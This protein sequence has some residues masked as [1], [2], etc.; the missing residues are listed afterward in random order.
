MTAPW[1]TQPA[2]LPPLYAY[3]TP[4]KHIKRAKREHDTRN[5]YP[6]PILTS[7]A[8][9]AREAQSSPA[10]AALPTLQVTR[11]PQTVGRS[12]KLADFCPSQTN[13]LLSRVH[14]RVR[15]E[16][17]RTRELVLECVGW[18]GCTLT[19]TD[20]IARPVARGDS[21]AAVMDERG[22]LLEMLGTR[23]LLTCDEQGSTGELSSPLTEAPYAM[24]GASPP[25]ASTAASTGLSMEETLAE[26]VL[27]LEYSSTATTNL[28]ALRPLFPVL[29]DPGFVEML[30]G[31]PSIG[32]I[33]RTGKDAAGKALENEYFFKGRGLRSC[34]QTHKQYFW[35]R[36]QGK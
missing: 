18:N 23:I 31:S 24:E 17:A 5:P 28:S 14:A 6:S 33:E 34:R 2:L 19:T 12:S 27:H 11:V 13:A 35:K 3:G 32:V 8:R 20:G 7:P 15:L 21:I 36:P 9:L 16:D 1:P 10:S 26:L 22:L 25:A 29:A 30:H 4:Q